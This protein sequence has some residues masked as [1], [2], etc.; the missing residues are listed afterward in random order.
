MHAFRKTDR[1][2][3]G[4]LCCSSQCGHIFSFF[5]FQCFICNINWLIEHGCPDLAKGTV[6]SKFHNKMSVIKGYKHILKASA[7]HSE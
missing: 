2:F 3:A 4:S 7:T 5:C 1:V 6:I